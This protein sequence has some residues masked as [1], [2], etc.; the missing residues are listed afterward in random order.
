MRRFLPLV[1]LISILGCQPTTPPTNDT[2]PSISTSIEPKF[3][4]TS[5]P[6]MAIIT[7]TLSVSPDVKFFIV[8]KDINGEAVWTDEGKPG[9]TK[10]VFD[11]PGSQADKIKTVSIVKGK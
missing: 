9:Q 11:L 5:N 8:C 4:I 1:L 7:W 6:P 10:G 2:S 3:T